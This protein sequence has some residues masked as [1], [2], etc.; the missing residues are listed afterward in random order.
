MAVIACAEQYIF[1]FYFIHRILFLLILYP[2]HA[3]S[4]FLLPTGN[5]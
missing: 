5:H 2:Y 1:A 4:S 3:L